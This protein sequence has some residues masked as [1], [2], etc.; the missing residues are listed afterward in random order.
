MTEGRPSHPI[1]ERWR[2]AIGSARSLVIYYG[3][4]MRR[5]RMD[6]LYSDFVRQG[7]L[8]FDIGSH[9][10]DRIGSFRRL[11]CRVVAVEPQPRLV[12]ILRR[13]YG[14]DLDVA[15]EPMAIAA[16]PGSIELFV[17]LDNASLTTAS[18]GFVAAASAAPGWHG[19][20]WP[21]RLVAPAIT[22]D[23]LIE[24][25]GEPIF[26]KI[27]VE[28]F[29]T[30]AL[31]GLSRPLEAISFE[32]TTIMRQV[33]IDC[34]TRCRA[35]GAYR[36]NAALGESQRLAFTQWVDAEAI[37]RW[38]EALPDSANSG[39]VYARLRVSGNPLRNLAHGQSDCACPALL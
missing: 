4:P 17:N 24:R 12:R 13:F 22:L 38:L 2:S 10:G 37:E 27:D 15:I 9:V 33:A 18:S 3:N 8:V 28:G 26:A 34:V 19:E 31:A 1:G 30:E 20:R 14:R 21:G 5:R 16:A 29:E 6:R 32:F 39:D 11:G 36:Y 23:Q 35:L 7:D 25:H